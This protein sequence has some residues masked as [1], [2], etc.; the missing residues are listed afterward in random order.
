M[1]QLGFFPPPYAAVGIQNHVRE[2]RLVWGT[3]QRTLLYWL[4]YRTAAKFI[5]RC[6]PQKL[7]LVQDIVWRLDSSTPHYGPNLNSVRIQIHN[8]CECKFLKASH[9]N[10]LF[11][12][13]VLTSTFGCEPIWLEHVRTFCYIFLVG[14]VVPLILDVRVTSFYLKLAKYSSSKKQ[15]RLL[16]GTSSIDLFF[17]TCRRQI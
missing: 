6:I 12:H 11:S 5:I 14:N 4:S 15:S 16:T 9:P 17:R 13:S 7:K 3:F 10:P 1:A 2:L 8:S